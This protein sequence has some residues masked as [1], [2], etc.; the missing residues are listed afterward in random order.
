MTGLGDGS[1]ESF[2]AAIK[3]LPFMDTFQVFLSIIRYK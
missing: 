1:E 3:A 2:L